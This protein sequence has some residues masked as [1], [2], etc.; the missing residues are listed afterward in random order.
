MSFFWT[1]YEYIWDKYE[2]FL[3]RIYFLRQ[4]RVYFGPNMSIFW[5]KY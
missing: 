2:Y 4:R 5:C 3:Y 1:K